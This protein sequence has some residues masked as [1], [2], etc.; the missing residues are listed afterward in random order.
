MAKNKMRVKLILYSFVYIFYDFGI[1]NSYV[2]SYKAYA[3]RSAKACNF[4]PQII[5][6]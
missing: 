3:T 6:Y 5:S 1:L 2:V 4:S